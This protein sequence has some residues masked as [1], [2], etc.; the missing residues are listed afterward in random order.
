MAA[1]TVWITFALPDSEMESLERDFEGCRFFQAAPSSVD[2]SRLAEVDALFVDEPLPDDLLQRMSGLT[3][4]HTTRGGAY[5]FL[6]PAVRRRPIQ[7]TCSKGIHGPAFSE[8]ALASI[9]ALAKKLPQCWEAQ[10][11]RRWHRL[12]T[13]EVAGKTLGIVG[14]GTVGTELA[15]MAKGLGMRVIATKRTTSERSAY[16]DELGTPEFLLPLLARS[17]FVVLC[18]ASV[19]STERILGERELR[20]MKKSAYLINITGGKAI[21][22]TLLVRALK[23][24]WIAGAAL[25]ALPR[26]P[27]PPESELWGLPNVII[28]ARIGGLA[29]QKWEV[30]VPMFA[31]NLRR[32]LAGETLSNAVDKERGY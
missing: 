31:D 28:S 25:D 3:W 12:T 26:Q 5:P 22:E 17:D 14:L 32:F 20:S 23:E 8:F 19:P 16:V 1:C 24:G 21:E 18:L 11:Q 15:R 30:L 9:F 10:S 2:A 27:L 7:V 29:A 6:T 13:E 4:L